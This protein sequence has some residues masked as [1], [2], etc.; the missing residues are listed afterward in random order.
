MR[1]PYTQLYA[2]LVYIH[3]VWATWDRLPIVRPEWKPKLCECIEAQCAQ[4]GVTVG[5]LE[6]MPDHAH[7]LVRMP[8][9]VTIADLVKQVKG[10]SSHLVTQ[11]LAPGEWFKWQGAYGAFTVSKSD[12]RRVRDYIR[13]QENHHREK[14]LD[15]ELER[16][17]IP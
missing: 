1:E 17:E 2:H 6:L 4:L 14:T 5:A 3:L 12:V 13:N 8:T 15:A 11:E 10:A 9:T 7:L 16:T